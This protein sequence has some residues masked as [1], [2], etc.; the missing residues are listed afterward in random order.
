MASDEAGRA[1]DENA[2]HLYHFPGS[3]E[4]LAAAPSCPWEKSKQTQRGIAM[5][6]H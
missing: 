1:G 2:S 4:P 6:I 5:N 3:Q